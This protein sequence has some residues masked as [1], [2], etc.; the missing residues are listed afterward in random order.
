[1]GS[2]HRHAQIAVGDE[3]AELVAVI[4]GMAL[5]RPRPS[6]AT[7]HRRAVQIAERNGLRERGATRPSTRSCGRW[8]RPWSAHHGDKR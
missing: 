4:E 6:A 3:C 2:P 5:R 7:V 1:L 8:T